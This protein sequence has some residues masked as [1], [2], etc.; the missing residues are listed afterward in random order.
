MAATDLRYEVCVGTTQHGCQ[1]LPLELATASSWRNADLPLVCSSTYFFLVRVVN[2]AGLQRTIVSSGAKLCCSAPTGG[3]VAVL[4][5][6]R[7]AVTSLRGGTGSISIASFSDECSGVREHNISL[8][9]DGVLVWSLSLSPSTVEALLPSSTLLGLVDGT[10][11]N[12]SVEATNH[13]GLSSTR[14]TSFTID[15]SSPGLTGSPLLL[16]WQPMGVAAST[17]WYA[18]APA[19]VP[20]I[21][22]SLEVSWSAYFA[23]QTGG[24]LTYSFATTA[25]GS[26]V[27]SAVTFTP[28][29]S[30]AL[31]SITHVS[32]A[33]PT[34]RTDRLL[35]QCRLTSPLRNT[36]TRQCYCAHLAVS[37]HANQVPTSKVFANGT[38]FYFAVRACDAV[39][40]CLTSSFHEARGFDV[41]GQV[42]PRL[43]LVSPC[44]VLSCLVPSRPTPPRSVL[45]LSNEVAS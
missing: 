5:V 29:S 10:E 43:R 33:P 41:E 1:T 25:N 40:L 17:Q 16:R 37:P 19:C 31:A 18:G 32:A 11:C 4:G 24:L 12:V 7:V 6:S 35:R 44:L 38:N 9:A 13:A 23:D 45:V 39:G 21:S 22:V 20:A 36:S 26:E 42:Q 34:R 14:F 8:M 30:E 2:C 27:A 15:R 28:A 3:S